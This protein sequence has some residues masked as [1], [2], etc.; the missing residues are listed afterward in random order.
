MKLLV[1]LASICAALSLVNADCVLSTGKFSDLFTD[2][3]KKLDIISEDFL[4][5]NEVAQIKSK[6]SCVKKK[7]NYVD[8]VNKT[9]EE[10]EFAY[11][12]LG[13]CGLCMGNQIGFW[14]DLVDKFCVLAKKQNYIS[15]EHVE[16]LQL[17]FLKFQPGSPF[18]R[19][20][21]EKTIKEDTLMCAGSNETRIIKNAI[22]DGDMS[23]G[24][25]SEITCGSVSKRKA[26]EF[27]LNVVLLTHEKDQ[28]IVD[29]ET[30]KLANSIRYEVIN[31]V[32]C[33]NDKLEFD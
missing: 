24:G 7:I 4:T 22:T 32:D 25:Y 29:A 2:L 5:K 26:L 28:A 8:N 30:N 18:L 12:F 23:S 15:I 9:V 3:V 33:V 6:I 20:L 13:A 11:L 27:A 17:E 1:I 14:T 31:M 21:D 19:N 16:C 10:I